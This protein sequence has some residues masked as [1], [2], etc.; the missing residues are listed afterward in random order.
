MARPPRSERRD[1]G[2]TLVE[3][4][5]ALAVVAS[6]LAAI[7]ALVASNGRTSRALSDRLLLVSA[8][9]TIMADLGRPETCRGSRLGAT[10]GVGWRADM[11]P[12][13]SSG[14]PDRPPPRWL[15]CEIVLRLVGPLGGTMELRTLRL[16]E[17]ARP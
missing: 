11:L 10:G 8:A 2:F 15:P 13:A 6:G 5:V 14:A 17:A 16:A 4:L 12:R 3:V 9:R 7:G 1:A